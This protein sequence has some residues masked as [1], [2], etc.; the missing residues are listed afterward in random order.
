LRRPAELRV[1]AQNND[2]SLDEALFGHQAAWFFT[3][4]DSDF[5]MRGEDEA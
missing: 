4:A 2:P 3:L 5:D 1:I